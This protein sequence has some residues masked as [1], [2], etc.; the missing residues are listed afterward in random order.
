[1]DLSEIKDI[2][3]KDGGKII[4]VENDK[5]QMVVMSFD[6]YKTKTRERQEP[7]QTRQQPSQTRQR[8]LSE[9]MPKSAE[10][11]QEELSIEDLPL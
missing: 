2:I 1:M 7:S 10:R 9:V 6:E 8:P 5:P 4:I 11:E 3:Q